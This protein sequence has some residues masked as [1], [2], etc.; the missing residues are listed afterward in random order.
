ME[1]TRPEKHLF[2]VFL[3]NSLLLFRDFLQQFFLKARA[4][5]DRGSCSK[6][7]LQIGGPKKASSIARALFAASFFNLKIGLLEDVLEMWI[8]FGIN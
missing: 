7:L 8:K 3:D 1:R 2:K 6:S 4:H 5:G